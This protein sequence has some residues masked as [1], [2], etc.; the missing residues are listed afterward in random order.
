[1]ALKSGNS[2]QLLNSFWLSDAC[3]DVLKENFEGIP[4]EILK[5]IDYFVYDIIVQFI[6]KFLTTSFRVAIANMFRLRPKSSKNS[7]GR[8]RRSVINFVELLVAQPIITSSNFKNNFMS[9]LIITRFFKLLCYCAKNRE[10]ASKWS[11]NMADLF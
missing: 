6:C 3:A 11:H 9:V 2:S 4:L 5:R 8:S 1:M 10:E 7:V